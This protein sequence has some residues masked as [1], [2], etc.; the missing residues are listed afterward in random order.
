M[1]GIAGT[2]GHRSTQLLF[3]M[4][5]MQAYYMFCFTIDNRAWSDSQDNYAQWL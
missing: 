4:C 1:Q 2:Q 3:T 5:I